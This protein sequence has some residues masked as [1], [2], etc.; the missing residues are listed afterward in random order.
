MGWICYPQTWS[1]PI[2]PKYRPRKLSRR[3]DLVSFSLTSP[4]RMAG[5]EDRKM[6][7]YFFTAVW[8]HCYLGRS[9]CHHH[10]AGWEEQSHSS[11]WVFLFFFYYYF[12]MRNHRKGGKRQPLW[13]SHAIKPRCRISRT[14]NSYWRMSR[15]QAAW[16]LLH[17][18]LNGRQHS[19]D[20]GWSTARLQVSEKQLQGNGVHK[21]V[22]LPCS[23]PSLRLPLT[24]THG[25]RCSRLP[26]FGVSVQDTHSPACRRRLLPQAHADGFTGMM[27]LQPCSPRCQHGGAAHTEL[28]GHNVLSL[29]AAASFFCQAQAQPDFP[30]QLTTALFTFHTPTGKRAWLCWSGCLRRKFRGRKAY[31]SHS[32]LSDPLHHSPGG[33]AAVTDTHGGLTARC[34]EQHGNARVWF[35]AQ[36]AEAAGGR[37]G[38]SQAALSFTSTNAPPD[39]AAGNES[40]L[41]Y[42]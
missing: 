27:L 28:R 23:E 41:G 17:C 8:S 26:C 35:T 1:L 7:W 15:S 29:P 30:V 10:T 19:A 16:V 39:Y 13:C 21:W 25:H 22:C 33:F 40:I 31:W 11:S 9:L 14:E 36:Q 18:W 20:K 32:S 42:N 12:L 2:F 37:T 34:Q 6:S 38:S 5:P 3:P 24:Y 4:L